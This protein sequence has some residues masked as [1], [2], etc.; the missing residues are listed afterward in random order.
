MI[1]ILWRRAGGTPAR[2]RTVPRSQ[3]LLLG[4]GGLDQTHPNGKP[5]R[6]FASMRLKKAPR[7]SVTPIA[8]P[9]QRRP[10]P[11]I[12][13]IWSE[14]SVCISTSY[15]TLLMLCDCAP[16]RQHRLFGPTRCRLGHRARRS[17]PHAT[18]LEQHL[19][20]RLPKPF[21]R[22]L[23]GCVEQKQRG[24]HHGP[25]VVR[26]DV[27]VGR[28]PTSPAPSE[29]DAATASQTPL[30]AKPLLLSNFPGVRRQPGKQT[31]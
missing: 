22:Q 4:Q 7:P 6:Y 3:R 26:K 20:F 23:A 8:M 15:S 18:R 14:L 31:P 13:V 28:P 30:A 10:P 24:R 16:R 25:E 29:R 1:S 17:V 2:R 11:S 27:S 21:P 9:H 19:Q 5:V 12:S